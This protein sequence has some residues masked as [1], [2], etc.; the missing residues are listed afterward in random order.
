MYT[1]SET[2]QAKTLLTRMS[3][4]QR[5]KTTLG[6]TKKML[7]QLIDLPFASTS[8]F[9]ILTPPLLQNQLIYD[10]SS[11]KFIRVRIRDIV[12]YKVIGQIF[13]RHDYGLD[14]LSRGQELKQH[15]QAIL[16][17][18]RTP[19]VLDCG[20]HC[21]MAVRYF[22]ETYP[23]AHIVAVE[24]N[25][26]NLK[27]AVTNNNSNQVTYMLAGVGSSDTRADLHDPGHGN[28]SYRVEANE[29][30]HV[31]IS[32]INTL[33][34]AYGSER[35]SPF[36]IKIDI[37]GFERNL[38]EKNTEWIDGFPLLVIELHD[39]MLPRQANARNFLREVSSRNRDFVFF[40]ENVF[41]IS[42]TII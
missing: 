41:S 12:D 39:W 31:E 26:S 34:K 40:G 6:W 7:R 14:K 38:F 24:P 37:E 13:G 30:G 11:K 9:T 3:N 27:S 15:Y 23:H 17:A 28:W 36:I 5:V 21:G 33:L 42:N 20:A 25:E 8:R 10:N 16:D 19:L 1:L 18:G 2:R 29:N 32:S 35:F 4:S 22:A